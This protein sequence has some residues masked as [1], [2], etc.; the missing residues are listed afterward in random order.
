ML[1]VSGEWR[2]LSL[3]LQDLRQDPL[4]S[5]IVINGLDRTRETC[6][7]ARLRE[8][9]DVEALG[10]F[11][12]GLAHDLNNV[13]TVIRHRRGLRP[14]RPTPSGA[15]PNAARASRVSCLAL[16]AGM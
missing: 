4:V 2:S 10:V 12:S 15:L 1:S 3:R 7:V 8:A 14:R 16:A 5:A 9:E 11:A 6:L 13:L